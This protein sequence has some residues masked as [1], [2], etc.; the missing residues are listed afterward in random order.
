M[1]SLAPGASVSIMGEEMAKENKLK[2]EETQMSHIT[3]QGVG[4]GSPN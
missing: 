3:G 1:S 2:N 4:Q